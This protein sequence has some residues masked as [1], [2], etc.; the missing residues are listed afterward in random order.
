VLIANRGEISVRIVRALRELGVTSVAVYSDPDREALHARIADEA[1]HVGPAP[2]TA[3]YLNVERLI[4]VARKSGAEAV[5]PGYGFLAES[6]AFARAVEGAGLVWI[7]P[8]PR[9]I[10]AMGSKALSA[11][12]SRSASSV[13]STASL[14]P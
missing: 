14:W 12:Q 13:R 2:A 8:H 7:G 4:E 9:A 6:A 3:S 5:H 10:E 1:Y 11:P